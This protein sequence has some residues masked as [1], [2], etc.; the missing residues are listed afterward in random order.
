[1]GVVVVF[2]D[3]PSCGGRADVAVIIGFGGKIIREGAVGSLVGQEIVVNPVS[4][5]A[6]IM[7]F[8]WYIILKLSALAADSIKGTLL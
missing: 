8:C 1:M 2:R 3:K 4:L 5:K 6:S 7:L